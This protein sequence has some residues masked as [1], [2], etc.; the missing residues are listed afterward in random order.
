MICYRVSI[1]K[2]GQVFWVSQPVSEERAEII[3]LKN[4]RLID[5]HGWQHIVRVEC[6]D[7]LGSSHGN[8]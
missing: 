7:A 6:V 8:R 4:Q 3:R 1:A 2:D 5:K